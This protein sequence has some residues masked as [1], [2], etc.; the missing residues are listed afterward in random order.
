MRALVRN[1]RNKDESGEVGNGGHRVFT[2]FRMG[3]NLKG[4]DNKGKMTANVEHQDTN[5]YKEEINEIMNL[6]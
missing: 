1:R 2:E 3:E 6:I 5:E 4:L